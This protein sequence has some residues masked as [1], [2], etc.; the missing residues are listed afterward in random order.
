LC[1]NN[2]FGRDTLSP[3]IVAYILIAVVSAEKVVKC[4]LV[5]KRDILYFYI[6]LI[7]IFS[8]TYITLIELAIKVLIM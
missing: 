7:V 2:T 6:Y 1:L 5:A 4:R 3:A 8:T